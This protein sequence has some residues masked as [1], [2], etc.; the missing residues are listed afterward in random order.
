M[1]YK[2][3]EVCV[4]KIYDILEFG[5]LIVFV[6]VLGTYVVSHSVSVLVIDWLKERKKSCPTRLMN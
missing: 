3:I 6:G 5:T 4:K 2:E 1:P